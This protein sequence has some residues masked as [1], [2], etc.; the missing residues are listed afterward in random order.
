MKRLISLFICLFVV[1]F[2]SHGQQPQIDFKIYPK[3][4]GA[5]GS[6]S[7]LENPVAYYFVISGLPPN[8]P[9]E[10]LHMGW[11]GA[12]APT[13]TRGSKWTG[14]SWSSPS[15][16]VPFQV[17]D[18]NGVIKAWV[19]L[20]PPTNFSSADSY[21]VRIR[22]RRA[23]DPRDT[24]E[25]F[26][27]FDIKPLIF[28]DT[29]TGEKAGSIIYGYTDTINL[30]L[31]GKVMVAY[32]NPT[33]VR[34]LAAWLIQRSTEENSDL[35]ITRMDST[36]RKNGY[37]QLLVP[38]NTRIGKLE[39]RDSNNVVVIAWVSNEWSSGAPGTKTVIDF[40][41]GTVVSVR[42]IGE[43]VQPGSYELLQNYPN[44]FNSETIIK[45]RVPEKSHVKIDIYNV[46]GQH[47]VTLVDGVYGSGEHTVKWDGKD[48]FNRELSS[49][50]YFY[51]MRSNGYIF[52]RKM[53]YIK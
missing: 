36:L 28:S 33:D 46:I 21:R 8:T 48:K 26:T 25:F 12:S 41:K 16:V 52:S 51:M 23:V 22:I 49:G 18:S 9:Y 5:V 24:V 13:S 29:A 37:F 20:R 14:S 3:Y 6:T 30:N 11:N 32:M 10:G 53:V 31:G 17:S 19:Y 39:V 40:S 50:I 43:S 7:T 47:V 27:N 35:F 15:T 38:A 44:P 45:F 1:I 42:D 34:P 4:V 2:V